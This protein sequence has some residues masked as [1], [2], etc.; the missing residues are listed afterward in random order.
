MSKCASLD[1]NKLTDLYF[2]LKKTRTLSLRNLSRALNYINTNRSIYGERAI[3]DGLV[4]GFGEKQPFAE[5][6]NKTVKLQ[7]KPG[8]I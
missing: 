4:L 5:Y 7:I 1:S 8:F 2:D 3:F 6:A